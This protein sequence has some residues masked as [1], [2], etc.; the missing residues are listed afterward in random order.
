MSTGM[1]LVRDYGDTGDRWRWARA[2]YHYGA[3]NLSWPDDDDDTKTKN[4]IIFCAMVLFLTFTIPWTVLYLVLGLTWTL[5]V[6]VPLPVSYVIGLVHM[7]RTKTPRLALNCLIYGIT[8]ATVVLLILFGAGAGGA[9]IMGP[10]HIAPLVSLV[11]G[12]RVRESSCL[13]V[14]IIAISLVFCVLEQTVGPERL[15]PKLLAFPDPWYATF[16]WMHPNIGGGCSYLVMLLAVTQLE[17]SNRRLLEKQVH[18]EELNDKLNRQ[19]QKLQLEQRLAQK[20]IS[21]VF[22]AKVTGTLIDLFEQC[23]ECKRADETHVDVSRLERRRATG[24]RYERRASVFAGPEH[25][26][27]PTG[28]VGADRDRVDSLSLRSVSSG[29]LSL[30]QGL[31]PRLRDT[32]NSV[33][34]QFALRLAPKS[35]PLSVVLFADIVGFTTVASRTD[36]TTLVYFLDRLFGDIDTNSVIQQFALRLAPKSHP[37]SVVLFADIVGFTTVASRTDATTLVYF[38]DRLFGDIDMACQAQQVDKVKT[39]GDCYMCVGWTEHPG[40]H[41]AT[42]LRVLRVARAMHSTIHNTLLDEHRLLVRAGMPRPRAV[43]PPPPALSPP[44]QQCRRLSHWPRLSRSALVSLI[45][46]GFQT[47][48]LFRPLPRSSSI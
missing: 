26:A 43:A 46:I 6:T 44:P 31:D 24:A 39:I 2:W 30:D 19:Q 28:P 9:G 23:A 11:L 7:W 8:W 38:L 20:L 17:S 42:A 41:A 22:P 21:N 13:V 15:T 1:T 32:T 29:R 37:L 12:K 45:P 48:R 36:A 3:E 47:D 4:L 34:Q 5:L 33:I 18:L 16:A 10:A 14:F 25:R 40:A 27:P 35:H